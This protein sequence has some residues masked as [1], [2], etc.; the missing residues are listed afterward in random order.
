[1]AYAF[2]TVTSTSA[3]ETDLYVGSDDGIKIW[4]NGRVVHENRVDR[5]LAVDE[6]G[7]VVK[8]EKGI[9]RILVKVDQ[10][11]VAWGFCLRFRDDHDELV[12]GL[13]GVQ[14]L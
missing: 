1:M 12:Y 3:L 6:D 11:V 2:A 10:G 7:V 9:N 4:I 14:G 8:L 13:E 5:G